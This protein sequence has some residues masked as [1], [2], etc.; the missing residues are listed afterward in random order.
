MNP[1]AAL[2]AY[3]ALSEE[4]K[5]FLRRKQLEGD[6]SPA[7]WIELLGA[8]AA[9]DA[10]GD[11]LRRFSG[12]AAIV[13]LP[14]AWF[15]IFAP[16]LGLLALSLPVVFFLLWWITRRKDVIHLREFV[17]PLVARVGDDVKNGRTLQMKLDL[18]GGEQKDKEVE[19]KAPY[20][21]GAYHKIVETVYADPWLSLDTVLAD[22]ARLRL[23]VSDQLRKLRGTKRTARG[24]TKIKTKYK[25]KQTVD[26]WLKLPAERYVPAQR[27][28]NAEGMREKGSSGEKWHSLHARRVVRRSD[29]KEPAALEPVLEMMT[30]LYSGVRPVA[31]PGENGHE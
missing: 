4:Q 25:I 30:H 2:S 31:A 21:K 5:R 23:G 10:H 16:P 29:R 28:N 1:I 9:Y 15:G 14:L 22:G 19:T 11:S 17:L 13:A 26:L 24:K 12:W 27:A 18:R 6:F 8:P 3:R 20:R 7:E